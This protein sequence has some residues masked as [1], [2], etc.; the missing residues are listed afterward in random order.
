MH[1]AKMNISLQHNKGFQW[2]KSD[3]LFFKGYFYIDD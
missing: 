1:I 2:F 3:S